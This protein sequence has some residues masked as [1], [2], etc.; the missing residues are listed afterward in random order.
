ME[1]N[2]FKNKE[3][4]IDFGDIKTEANFKT[5]TT[6]N[7]FTEMVEKYK[8]EISYLA[9][10]E[11]NFSKKMLATA[12]LT[13]E[14]YYIA[15]K[16]DLRIFR[17]KEIIRIDYLGRNVSFVC[18]E[19]IDNGNYEDEMFHSA[20]FEHLSS[21]ET[22]D[23]EKYRKMFEI[24]DVLIPK[25]YGAKHKIIESGKTIKLEKHFNTG[26]VWEIFM[27][28]SAV[29]IGAKGYVDNLK[30]DEDKETEH[31]SEELIPKGF[32]DK[33]LRTDNIFMLE[34]NKGNLNFKNDEN[35]IE[36]RYESSWFNVDTKTEKIK[37]ICSLKPKTKENGIE[38]ASKYFF[39]LIEKAKEYV[40]AEDLEDAERILSKNIRTE[41][42]EIIE[43]LKDVSF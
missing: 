12:L 4:R 7:N 38:E 15:E 8:N 31:F 11:E 42:S 23:Y 24:V 2:I 6:E 33:K 9:I 17:S 30:I 10:H 5:E 19:E 43:K 20:Y 3:I 34:G 37:T 28:G 40:R 36:V 16:N 25:H 13:K 18:K 35:L 41:Y 39:I 1:L 27:T 32:E 29:A 26:E 14:F 22:E 21:L